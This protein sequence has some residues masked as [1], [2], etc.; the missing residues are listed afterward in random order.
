[1]GKNIGGGGGDDEGFFERVVGEIVDFFLPEGVDDV[2]DDAVTDQFAMKASREVH[3]LFQNA[4]LNAGQQAVAD[5]VVAAMED[6]IDSDFPEADV[7]SAAEDV[8]PDDFEALSDLI[9]EAAAIVDGYQEEAL[10]FSG[11][12]AEE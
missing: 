1:M 4:S 8:L 6:A 9:D 11:E 5:E 7:A 3:S 2:V 12:S 10:A